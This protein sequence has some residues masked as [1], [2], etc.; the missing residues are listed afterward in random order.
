VSH[1]QKIKEKIIDPR[2]LRERVAQI[3]VSN[4]KIAL[5]NGS[6]DLLHAGHLY[7]LSEAAEQGDFLIVALN[8]DISIKKYKSADRPIITL[9]YRLQMMAALEMVDA[10]TWFDETD[11]CALLRVIRPDVHVNGAEY[12]ENCI[13]AGT[14]KEIGARLH[15]VKRIPS[16]SSSEIVGKIHA[17]R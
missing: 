4:K 16:L 17:L 12:G 9:E 2:I 11:P 8:S 7:I 10:V 15:L 13:E 14:V 3:K 5:I 6:F 1:F